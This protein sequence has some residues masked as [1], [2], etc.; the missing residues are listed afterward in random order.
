MAFIGDVFGGSAVCCLAWSC[1][2][3]VLPAIRDE[4]FV[5]SPR[6]NPAHLSAVGN[7]ETQA[8]FGRSHYLVKKWKEK[9]GEGQIKEHAR[10]FALTYFNSIG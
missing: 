10:I 7:V 5:T 8:P 4:Y 2:G 1:V 3:C 9:P 6:W